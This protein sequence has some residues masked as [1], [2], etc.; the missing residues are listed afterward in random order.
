MG[1]LAVWFGFSILSR[2]DNGSLGRDGDLYSGHRSR[3]VFE[4]SEAASHWSAGSLEDNCTTR[5]P[6]RRPSAAAVDARASPDRSRAELLRA[7]QEINRRGGRGRPCRAW[8]SRDV[9]R[10]LRICAAVTFARLHVVPRLPI[11]LAAHPAHD[12]DIVM[13]DGDTDL[14]A[15]GIDV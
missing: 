8:R 4:R 15:N 14:V 13:E 10:R 3:V 1:V 6:A 7:R 11:F 9:V 12:V 5:R 2:N